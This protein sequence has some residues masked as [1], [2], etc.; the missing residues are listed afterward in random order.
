MKKNLSFLDSEF[1]TFLLI[2]YFLNNSDFNID[3][4]TYYYAPIKTMLLT[5]DSNEE[6]ISIES[7]DFNACEELYTAL[8]S[9]KKVKQINL[10]IISKDIKFDFI[11]KTSPLRITKVNAPKSIAEEEY[12]RIVERLLYV[13]LV[14]YI[15]NHI[16]SLI[17]Q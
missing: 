1:L 6:K 5:S 9:N 15:R 7:N 10:E 11:L 16:I 17:F 8:K 14:R 12:D 3:G 4:K 2:S 13:D